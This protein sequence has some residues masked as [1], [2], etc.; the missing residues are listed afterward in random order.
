MT[1]G[2]HG[3]DRAGMTTQGKPDVAAIL[4]I[5]GKLYDAAADGTRWPNFLHA[6][7]VAFSSNG[8]QV[9]RVQPRNSLLNFS[10]LYGY[11]SDLIRMY[12]THDLSLATQRF[13]RHFA[14]LMP[15]DPRMRFL[16]HYP[17]RP[18]SCRLEID[19]TE[20]HNSQ[21]YRDMLRHAGVEY[22][23][24]VSLA[25]E[26]SSLIILGVFRGRDA[27][28]FTHDDVATF[29][30]IIPHLKQAIEVSEHLAGVRF[31][32][33]SALGA[34]DSVGM[35]IFLVGQDGRLIHGNR[36]GLRIAELGDGLSVNAGS[37]RAHSPTH[38]AALRR[39]ISDSMR[40]GGT[41]ALSL[42]RRSGRE[43]IPM[44][45]SRLSGHLP[46]A[47]DSQERPVAVLLFSLPEAPIETPV[48]MLRRLF[49]LTPAEARVCEQLVKGRSVQDAAADLAITIDTARAH[50]KKIFAK[51]GVN[52]Q[53]E[54][55]SKVAASPAWVHRSG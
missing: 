49:G 17:S 1:P 23:L 51:L 53:A 18:L 9:V 27:S 14:E 34:L 33:D 44:T 19:E 48:D 32:A 16:E 6:M 7:T 47:P 30:E 11:D 55:I 35:G 4:P 36:A 41:H 45:V 15:T 24:V 39:A 20:L 25:E 50:L 10:A 37:V 29:S 38:D 40:S 5:I 52:R 8:A 42:A 13:E 43:P 28:H 2:R 54:L 12:D 26:D 22:S 3:I 21:I 31:E 46:G